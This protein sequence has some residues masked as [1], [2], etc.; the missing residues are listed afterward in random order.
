MQVS[1]K[2]DYIIEIPDNNI[3]IITAFFKKVL[4]LF[5]REFILTLV[6]QGIYEYRVTHFVPGTIN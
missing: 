1:I 2:G 3:E 6:N 4:L 5:L